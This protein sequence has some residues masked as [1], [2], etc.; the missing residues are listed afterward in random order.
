[1][2]WPNQFSL[3][4]TPNLPYSQL[5]LAK[6]SQCPPGWCQVLEFFW[7]ILLSPRLSTNQNMRSK[8]IYYFYSLLLTPFRLF[9][10][11]Q[12]VHADLESGMFWTLGSNK[13]AALR[14]VCLAIGR[15]QTWIDDFHCE[16]ATPPAALKAKVK[17][18]R[19]VPCPFRLPVLPGHLFKLTFG[20]LTFFKTDMNVTCKFSEWDHYCLT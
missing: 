11:P 2:P 19:H 15:A 9:P 1:M 14:H 8:V 3:T 18:T 20:F 10:P 13:G 7:T 12:L 6:L 4:S 5:V 17:C 16:M